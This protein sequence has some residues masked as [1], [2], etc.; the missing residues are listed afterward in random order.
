MFADQS[1]QEHEHAEEPNDFLHAKLL[2]GE[3]GQAGV[4]D[5]TLRRGGEGQAEPAQHRQSLATV[6]WKTIVMQGR[7]G[8]T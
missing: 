3:L 8:F 5:D 4:H 1:S 6:R 7:R 2:L